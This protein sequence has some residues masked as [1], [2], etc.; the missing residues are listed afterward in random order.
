MWT[1]KY[2]GSRVI[3]AKI[4]DIGPHFIISQKIESV[5][6]NMDVNLSAKNLSFLP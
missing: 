2:S 4:V 5:P 6:Q 3:V 1:S